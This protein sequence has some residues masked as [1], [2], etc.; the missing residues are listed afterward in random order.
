M[1]RK[2]PS[3]VTILI[4]TTLTSVMWI[5]LSIYRAIATE[6]AAVV[7][8]E[9]S[10]TLNPELDQGTISEIQK[11]IFLGEDQIPATIITSPAPTSIPEESPTPTPV[12][13]EEMQ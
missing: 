5:T 12:S 2:I 1:K 13:E 9:I 3:L 11:R 4:L 10:R 8:E 6:P 7:P